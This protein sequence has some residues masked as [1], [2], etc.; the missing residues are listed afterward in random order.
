M[1]KDLHK[2]PFDENTQ[3][4][5]EIFELYTKEW[6]PTF[7]MSRVGTMCIFDFFAGTGYDLNHVPGSPIRILRQ[8]KA[9]LGNIFQ[10]GTKIHVILNEYDKL[11]YVQLKTV[12]EEYIESTP[13]LK[14]AKENNILTYKIY[15]ED[16]AILFPK[17][18][19]SINKYPSLVFLDQNGVKFLSDV[20]FIP[21]VNSHCTDFLYFVS[22][23]YVKRFGDTNEF[24]KSVSFDKEKAKHEPLTQIHRNILEE[25]KKRIPYGNKTHLY[26]FTI[27]KGA[28][29]YGIIF[30]ASHIRAVDKFL[31]TAWKENKLNGEAN[32]DIDNDSCKGVP[33]L[34]GYVALTKIQ[35]FQFSLREKILSGQ[36]RTNKDVYTYTLEQG[37]IPAHA[38]EVLKNMKKE[39]VIYHERSPMVNYEQ[40]YKNKK[41]INY[42][43]R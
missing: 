31:S 12:C 21:L 35:K 33:D 13:E 36:L 15:N 30:G 38:I 20:Y 37:H 1:I 4:K 16:F 34:F 26:P 25:L 11:K 42:K 43:I 7:I 23:S 8:I 27:K 19:E 39:G 24:R 9:Q 14:R 6:L 17:C 40:V 41:L 22:S 5:L 2:Q 29:V 3:K 10:K 18:I 32:F 28:N